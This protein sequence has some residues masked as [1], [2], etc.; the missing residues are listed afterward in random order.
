MPVRVSKNR[1]GTYKVATPGGT[2]A[3]RT[4][5]ARAEA[6]QRLLNALDHG[7]KKPSLANA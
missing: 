2:K 3:K 6:Q 4:T 7:W 5:K 1:D